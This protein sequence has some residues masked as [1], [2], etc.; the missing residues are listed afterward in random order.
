LAITD[1][2]NERWGW[3]LTYL[4]SDGQ[5]LIMD[6]IQ[7]HGGAI[8][9]ASGQ[10][11]A[12]NSPETIAGVNW[13]VE[14]YT[15]PEW[16]SMLPPGVHS[17]T[18]SSNNE[19]YLAGK[20]GLTKNSFSLYGNMKR[21]TPDIYEDTA[22]I[23]RPHAMNGDL[24]EQGAAA[25]L[26]VFKGAKNIEAAK[27]YCSHMLQPEAFNPMVKIGAG[28][29]LP[30]YKNLYTEEVLAYDPN[31]PKLRDIMFNP[32][33]Y[34]GF[35]HPAESTALHASI[36]AATILQTMVSKAV[37]GEMSVEAA[38]QDAHDRIVTIWEEGG[39]PQA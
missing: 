37:S 21:D 35:S 29:F 18:D 19:A 9:D 20:V 12:F 26:V 30:C 32:T 5:G 10:V 33:E 36:S 1:V 3:G 15:A 16:A 8:T 28:L 4:A 2:E 25:W 24:L 14:T 23:N 27:A 11:V 31:I 38:V 7:A 22:V 6:C 34:K 39:I 17:W 13:L